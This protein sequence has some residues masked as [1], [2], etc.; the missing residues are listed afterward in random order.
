M[1]LI[2]NGRGDE[3][4]V[5]RMKRGDRWRWNGDKDDW[6]NG[7]VVVVGRKWVGDLR[8]GGSFEIEDKKDG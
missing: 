3:R 2:C 1:V 4:G 7:V 8:E 6:E 5:G